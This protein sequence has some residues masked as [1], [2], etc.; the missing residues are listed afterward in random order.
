MLDKIVII[1]QQECNLQAQNLIL[2][3]VSGGPDSICLLHVLHTLGYHILAAHVNH[4]L[5]P[6][7]DEEAQMVKQFAGDLGVD[8]ISC[9]ADVLSYA[10]EHSVSIEEAARNMRYHYLFEQAKKMGASAVLVGH[11]ADDQVET[12]LMHLLRGSGLAG[13]RGMEYRTV[14]NPWSEHI[15]LIRPLLSTKREDIL[16]YLTE[17]SLN[18]ISDHSNLDTTF[19]RNRLR[20]ELLPILEKYNPRIRENLL[21]VG[22]I[23]RDDYAVLQQ[24]AIEAWEINLVGQGP[25][26]LAFNLTG[27]RKL[28]TSLQRYLLRKSIAYH[29]PGL[30]DVDFECIER[31][32]FILNDDK[33]YLQADLIGGLC[34]IKDGKLFWLANWQADLPRAD[35]PAVTVDKELLLKIPSTLSISSNW[36]LQAVVVPFQELVM[37]QSMANLDPFQVWLDADNLETPLIVRYRKTGDRIQ[38]LGMDGHSMKVSDLMINLKLPKRARSTWPLVCSGD[39]ILW[40]PGYRLSHLVRIKSSSRS[41]IHLTLSRNSAT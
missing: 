37:Q 25:G 31:G 24:L 30:R 4:R 18:T 38:P 28:T 32:L 5:R 21:R 33:P 10:Y 22:Q 12:I 14:P 1:L 39:V 17:H 11:N 41:I 16:K 15:P 23:T 19:F 36:K 27:F 9:Q 3:G 8:F 35:F 7:A 6:E 13:L 20:H 34:I 2:V 29:L 26:Y 40:V